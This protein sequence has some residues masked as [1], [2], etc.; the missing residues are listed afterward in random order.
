M[1]SKLKCFACECKVTGAPKNRRERTRRTNLHPRV[2]G[3]QL[4]NQICPLVNHFADLCGLHEGEGDVR[5]GVET[6]D[7]TENKQTQQFA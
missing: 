1:Q 2:L 5:P 7:L 6:H 3:T 4:Y